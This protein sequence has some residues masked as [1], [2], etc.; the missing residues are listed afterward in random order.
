MCDHICKIK[1]KETMKFGAEEGEKAKGGN[2]KI[3][4]L[5]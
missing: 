1:A 3:I 5:V 4:F 2:G